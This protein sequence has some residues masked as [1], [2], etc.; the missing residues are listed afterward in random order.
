MPSFKYS[1]TLN[2]CLPAHQEEERERREEEMERHVRG[3]YFRAYLSGQDYQY[4]SGLPATSKMASSSPSHSTSS[5]ST[6]YCLSYSCKAAS[7][8]DTPP[9]LSSPASDSVLVK[10]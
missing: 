2:S 10:L 1:D 5:L 6:T 7:P 3:A 8:D 9:Q 4:L